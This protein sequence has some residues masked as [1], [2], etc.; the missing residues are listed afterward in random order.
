[1]TTEPDQVTGLRWVRL[2]KEQGRMETKDLDAPDAQVLRPFDVVEFNLLRPRPNPPR[3]EDWIADFD[4]VPPQVVRHLEGERRSRFLRKYSDTAPRQVL[5]AQQRSLCLIKPDSITGS[6]RQK[7]DSAHLEARLAFKLEGRAY[8]GS[9][10]KGGFATTDPVW[11]ALG[12]RWL[13]DGGG[14]ADFDE[15]I[16]QARY[17]IEEVYLV[18]GLSRSLQRRFEPVIVG[19]HTV[20]EYQVP[21]AHETT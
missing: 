20:P 14:W 11:L 9:F 2:V 7:P 19:V 10:T 21:I 18:I 6:F 1:M 12:S 4:R 13:P 3:I 8:R 15:G 16:L 5:V 17:G